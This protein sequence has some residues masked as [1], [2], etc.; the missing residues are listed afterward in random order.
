MIVVF[1]KTLI[2]VDQA[3][4]TAEYQRHTDL[5]APQGHVEVV[6]DL[7]SSKLKQCYYTVQQPSDIKA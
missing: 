7:L 6:E 3:S 4:V 5:H 2:N 1:K